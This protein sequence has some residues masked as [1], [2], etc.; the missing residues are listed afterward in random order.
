MSASETIFDKLQTPQDG[1]HPEEWLLRYCTEVWEGVERVHFDFKEKSDSRDATLSEPDK[2]NLAKAVSGFANSG[3]GVLIWGISDKSEA[4]PIT[5]YVKF[6]GKC[7]ELCVQVTD[8]VVAGIDGACIA[9]ASG[10]NQ[11]YVMIHI[12][13]SRIH[14]HR[15]ILNIKDL[16]GHYYVRSGNSFVEASHVQLEDMFGRRPKPRLDLDFVLNA[17]KIDSLVEVWIEVIFLNSGRGLAKYPYISLSVNE[18]YYVSSYG[19]DNYGGT[20]LATLSS[21]TP[22][23]NGFLRGYRDVEFGSKSGEVVHSGASR[24][25]T[26]IKAEYA[27][28]ETN[29]D[30]EIT[31]QLAAEGCPVETKHFTIT[32]REV[33]AAIA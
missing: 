4:K 25:L 32:Q 6:L 33:L 9:S 12:P 1:M 26:Q 22:Y 27:Q 23:I 17:R 30:L 29:P 20:G 3:G 2:K 13:E 24:K 31:V 14:P 7:L 21:S 28:S 10:E 8:P 19:A 5:E 16:R 15:V 11:G 18:P